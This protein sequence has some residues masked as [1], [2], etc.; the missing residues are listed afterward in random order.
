MKNKLKIAKM[1]DLDPKNRE[2]I[3]MTIDRIPSV[4]NRKKLIKVLNESSHE[5]LFNLIKKYNPEKLI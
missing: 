3:I 5:D 1:L 2:S 4:A